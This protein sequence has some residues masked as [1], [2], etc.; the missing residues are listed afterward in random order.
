MHFKKR[1]GLSIHREK[2]KSLSDYT[3]SPRM[4]KFQKQLSITMGE[5]KSCNSI[6]SAVHESGT[7]L[8]FVLFFV[9]FLHN[10][11]SVS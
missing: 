5:E 3:S 9:K 4:E 6:G 2:K 11:W 8:V 1:R 7:W 10:F